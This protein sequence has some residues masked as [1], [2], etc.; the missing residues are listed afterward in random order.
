[1]HMVIVV[2]HRYGLKCAILAAA[3]LQPHGGRAAAASPVEI[4]DVL[5]EGRK[6]F[7]PRGRRRQ[8]RPGLSLYALGANF[9]PW[10][11]GLWKQTIMSIQIVDEC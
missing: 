5:S 3:P 11:S 10:D 8:Q 9:H 7:G 1:M 2:T 6:W 4:L